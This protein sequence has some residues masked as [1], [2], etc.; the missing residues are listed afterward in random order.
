MYGPSPIV[1]VFAR[2]FIGV[3]GGTGA[4][5]ASA[6]M[7]SI[8]AN[9]ATRFTVIWPVVSLVVIPEIVLALPLAYAVPPLMYALTNESAC[10]GI[11]MSRSRAYVTSLALIA[12]PFQYCR[13]G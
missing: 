1:P 7:S 11:L 10:Q 13:P 12:C 8:G 4:V 5:P 2:F 3:L 6:K 9:G